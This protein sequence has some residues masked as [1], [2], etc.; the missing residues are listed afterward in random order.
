MF[1]VNHLTSLTQLWYLIS[2]YCEIL[3]KSEKIVVKPSRI[4]LYNDIILPT[5]KTF[6]QSYIPYF[7]PYA[8]YVAIGAIPDTFLSLELK[9]IVKLIAVSIA[10]AWFFKQY[11]FG[12]LESKHIGISIIAA[13]IAILLWV[14]PLYYTKGQGGAGDGFSI[15]YFILRMINAALLVAVFEEL[16][17]RV[18]L[19]Q[20]FY[21]AGNQIKE[22]GLIISILDTFDQKPGSLTRLPLSYFSVIMVT[23]LFTIGHTSKEWIPAI[24]YFSFTNY[25]YKK[26]GS[27]WVCILIHGISNLTIALLVRFGGMVFLWN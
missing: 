27:I 11:R 24:L 15:T 6:L 5:E 20:Y 25:L 1:C 8:I 22:K 21:H 3:F 26:T 18:Y 9:Q 13:P 17:L 14:V 16:F 10:M 2:E 7:G 4:I 12:K 23:I 19:M